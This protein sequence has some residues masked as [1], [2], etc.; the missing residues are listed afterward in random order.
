M[1]P[2]KAANLDAQAACDKSLQ[3]VTALISEHSQ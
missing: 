1:R 2:R 3:T